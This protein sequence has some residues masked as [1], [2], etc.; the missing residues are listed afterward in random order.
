MMK[1]PTER[2]LIRPAGQSGSSQSATDDLAW[3]HAVLFEMTPAIMHP[4]LGRMLAR[5]VSDPLAVVAL[6]IM[7]RVAADKPSPEL[8]RY[9]LRVPPPSKDSRTA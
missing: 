6:R 9:C 4:G 7:N 1:P 3:Y 5:A 2:P 8:A